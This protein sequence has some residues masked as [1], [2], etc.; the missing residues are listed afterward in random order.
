M[1]N[2]WASELWR[3]IEVHGIELSPQLK[4]YA[5]QV[6][7]CEKNPSTPLLSSFKWSNV[8]T[9][10]NLVQFLQGVSEAAGV[11]LG[12]AADLMLQLAARNSDMSDSEKV[13]EEISTLTLRIFGV[14]IETVENW[15]E[16]DD[17]ELLKTI[18]RKLTDMLSVFIFLSMI[19][20]IRDRVALLETSGNTTVIAPPSKLRKLL[21]QQMQV[22]NLSG[23]TLG[24]TVAA[25][26]KVLTV[27]EQ[28][29]FCTCG[30]KHTGNCNKG[31]H[32]CDHEEFQ[33][34][35]KDTGWG[36]HWA[37]GDT[38]G[39]GSRGH[40]RGG[41]GFGGGRGG[42]RGFSGNRGYQG[43]GGN[44][45]H[46]YKQSSNAITV[47]DESL[48]DE[49]IAANAIKIDHHEFDGIVQS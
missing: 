18:A 5:V 13:W 24:K 29:H 26:R 16:S 30:N 46:G 38:R 25:D 21:R 23:K 14:T 43:R 39:G 15:E 8:T 1:V 45:G 31:G 4:A 49:A 10:E 28:K 19:P 20:E 17:M 3:R 9:G 42:G 48:L 35:R 47:E 32:A 2:Q 12:D 6:G 44:S 22:G 27:P 36:V 40:G 41:R 37:Q 34:L 11:P 7:I 33:R